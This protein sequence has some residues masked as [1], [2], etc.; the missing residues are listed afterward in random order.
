MSPK[1]KRPRQVPDTPATT[2]LMYA[3]VLSIATLI[4]SI[5]LVA[6]YQI[7]SKTIYP[8]DINSI[9][10]T[11][12]IALTTAI[13]AGG[14]VLVLMVVRISQN[15]DELGRVASEMK[16]LAETD[17]LTGLPNKIPTTVILATTLQALLSISLLPI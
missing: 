10:I 17:L 9:L 13:A 1:T 2:Y 11:F 15:Q 14:G 3:V 16:R 5:W 12:A 7:R 8:N 6:I 4:M